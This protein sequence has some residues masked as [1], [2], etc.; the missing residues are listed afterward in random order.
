MAD[1]SPGPKY[2]AAD[3]INTGDLLFGIDEIEEGQETVAAV[4]GVFDAIKWQQHGIPTV[5]YLK[6]RLSPKQLSLLLDKNI[7]TLVLVPDAADRKAVARAMRDASK[8]ASRVDAVLVAV[9]PDG[10]DPDELD[11]DEAWALLESAKELSGLDAVAFE[12]SSA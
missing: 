5:A 3:G 10:R 4:E 2:K 1:S 7:G 8:Y 12:L 11:R 6:D 9:Q